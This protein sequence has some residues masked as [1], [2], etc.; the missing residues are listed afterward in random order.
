KE[1]LKVIASCLDS[2]IIAIKIIQI[3]ADCFQWDLV[4]LA[5]KSVAPSYHRLRDSGELH[6]LDE[7]LL[8]IVRVASVEYFQGG[9]CM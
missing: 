7:Q 3:A 6:E 2:A 4:G 9:G 1:C 8:D 5:A